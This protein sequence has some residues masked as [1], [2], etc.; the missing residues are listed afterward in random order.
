MAC[1]HKITSGMHCVA[2][3]ETFA[4][5]EPFDAHQEWT[6]D[7]RGALR[8]RCLPVHTAVDDKGA[9]IWAPKAGTGHWTFARWIGNRPEVTRRG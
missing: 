3:H 6:T 2:C 9:Q 1:D 8:L 4:S 5:I 7:A